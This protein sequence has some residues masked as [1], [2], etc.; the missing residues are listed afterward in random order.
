GAE[1]V[2]LA[3]RR[4][5]HA[6]GVGGGDASH[7]RAVGGVARLDRLLDRRLAL[8][9]PELALAL[10]LVGAVAGVAVGGGDGLNVGAVIGRLGGRVGGRQAGGETEQGD[11]REE[12]RPWHGWGLWG[13]RVGNSYI[14]HTPS[15]PSSH[16]RLLTFPPDRTI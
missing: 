1:A 5:H 12:R 16:K 8:V 9:E 13:R 4:R 3:V 14:Y 2:L 15:P 11:D 10:A 6:V 7:E